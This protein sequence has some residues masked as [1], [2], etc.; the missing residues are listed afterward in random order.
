M[1]GLVIAAIGAIAVWWVTVSGYISTDDAFIDARPVAVSSQVNAAIVDVQ[2]TDNELVAAGTVLVRLDN[3]DFKAQVDHAQAQV[4]QDKANISHVEAQLSAQDARINQAEKQ[5]SE[6]QAALTFAR[7][8]DQRYQHLAKTGSVTVEQAQQ[9]TSNLLQAQ[10]ALAAA[11]ANTVANKQQLPVLQAEQ[12]Q[13]EAQLEQGQASLEQAQINLSRTVITAPVA[14]RV[15]RLTAAKGQYAA[16]GQPLMMF[17]ARK[18]WVT[19][20]FKETE[21]HYV[22]PGAPVNIEIDAYP[23]RTFKGHVNSIQ[24]GSG[25]AFSLLPSENATGNYVK[26]V[27]RVPVKIVFNKPPDVLLGPGMSVVPM[28]KVR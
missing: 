26:I 4:D 17:V 22:Q 11:Q 10:A 21:L 1:T 25:T 18:V 19:A 27:Q 13:A 2:V 14:G 23:G 28:V 12:K 16:V 5:A 9:Y 24:P 3:R 6:S 8:Q 20:N 7:Q 15:A